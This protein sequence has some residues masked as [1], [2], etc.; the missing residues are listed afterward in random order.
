MGSEAYYPFI[1]KAAEQIRSLGGARLD[2]GK[3]Q[4]GPKSVRK[5]GS[6]RVKFRRGWS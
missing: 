1:R 5:I 3:K 2:R 4:V 6:D